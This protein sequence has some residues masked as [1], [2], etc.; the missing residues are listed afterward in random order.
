MKSK[1]EI[2]EDF[3]QELYKLYGGYCTE[4]RTL[5]LEPQT[6]DEWKEERAN[7]GE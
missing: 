5:G 6:F 1:Q 7:G 3:K 2:Y 4:M